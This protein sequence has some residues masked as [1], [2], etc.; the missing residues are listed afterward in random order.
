MSYEVGSIYPARGT[1][2]DADGTLADPTTAVLRIGLP[3]G[4][5]DVE[6]VDPASEG[7]YEHDV[8]L[9][10]AGNWSFTWVG[11]GDVT[12]AESTRIYVAPNLVP[13]E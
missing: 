7:V 4:T 13:D 1:F 5:T 3:D 12:D 6:P 9:T 8:L 10:M 2:R 11:T